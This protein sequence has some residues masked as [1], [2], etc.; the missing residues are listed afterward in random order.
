MPDD[1]LLIDQALAAIAAA[2]RPLRLGA[3]IKITPEQSLV[4]DV[5]EAQKA[6]LTGLGDFVDSRA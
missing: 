1:D 6:A 3:M 4:H 2:P 5:Y